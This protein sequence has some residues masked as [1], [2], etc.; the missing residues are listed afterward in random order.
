[1]EGLIMITKRNGFI[2]GGITSLVLMLAAGWSVAQYNGLYDGNF[3]MC[4]DTNGQHLNWNGNYP[5]GGPTCGNTGPVQSPPTV[6]APTARTLTL[7]TAFQATDNTKP[8]IVSLNLTSTAA[9]T[10]TS[11]QTHTADIV[12]GATNAVASGTGTVVGRYSNSLTGTLVVGLAINTNSIAP[13]SFVLPAGWF[14]AIRQTSGTVTIVSA[15]DQS[16]G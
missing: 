13:V 3:P 11:G 5:G 14:A 10:L 6:S 8:S 1:M 4:L 12:I 7:A 16:I 9:L 15:Y 2:I